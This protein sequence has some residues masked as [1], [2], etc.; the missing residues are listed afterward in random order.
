MITKRRTMGRRS[1]RAVPPRVLTRALL[2]IYDKVRVVKKY[3]QLLQRARILRKKP[4]NLINAEKMR[5]N[6]SA[7][8]S[9]K[10]YILS[11]D[12]VVVFQ[13]ECVDEVKVQKILVRVDTPVHSTKVLSKPVPPPAYL[14]VPVQAPPP[15]SPKRAQSPFGTLFKPK[16]DLSPSPVLFTLYTPEVNEAIRYLQELALCKMMADVNK[17]LENSPQDSIR[18]LKSWKLCTRCGNDSA[19]FFKSMDSTKYKFICNHCIFNKKME[20]CKKWNLVNSMK[21]FCQNEQQQ[22]VPPVSKNPNHVAS[23]KITN[24]ATT[25]PVM[26]SPI[27]TNSSIMIRPSTMNTRPPVHPSN[28]RNIT[29][30]VQGQVRAQDVQTITNP[31]SSLEAIRRPQFPRFK[32]TAPV[33]LQAPQI[34]GQSYRFPTNVRSTVPRQIYPFVVPITSLPTSSSYNAPQN[35][36][37]HYRPQVDSRNPFQTYTVNIAVQNPPRMAA[38]F[39]QRTNISTPGLRLVRIPIESIAHKLPGNAQRFTPQ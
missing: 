22:A 9:M 8:K 37:F 39:A 13:Q 18:K 31:V 20:Q 28:V 32:Q 16:N 26:T 14:L 38:T 17:Y 29:N 2:K 36:T 7:E 12:A 30:P 23:S 25:A 19:S 6:L 1:N 24:I 5:A 15:E 27:M 21:D 10:K 4:P 34:T 33:T 11:Q 35:S 3:R